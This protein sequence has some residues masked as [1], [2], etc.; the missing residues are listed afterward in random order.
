MCHTLIRHIEKGEMLPDD[1]ILSQ[2]CY[3]TQRHG[4]T[5]LAWHRTA[6]T[7]F[8]VSLAKY[9]RYASIGRYGGNE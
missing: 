9:R 7:M 4:L 3:C 2:N 8:H 5:L 6:L 1:K